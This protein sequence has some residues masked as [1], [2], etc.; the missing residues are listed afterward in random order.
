[1]DVITSKSGDRLR[2]FM[3]AEEAPNAGVSFEGKVMITQGLADLG[4]TRREMTAILAHEAGHYRL[5]HPHQLINFHSEIATLGG[6]AA[7]KALGDLL[8]NEE[9]EPSR[10]VRER[11]ENPERFAT[12]YDAVFNDSLSQRSVD[13]YVRKLEEEAHDMGAHTTEKVTMAEDR[14]AELMNRRRALKELGRTV[15]K[16][17]CAAGVP[18]IV[19]HVDAKVMTAVMRDRD[20][21]REFAADIFSRD[22]MATPADLESALRKMSDWYATKYNIRP[23]EVDGSDHPSNPRRFE[24]LRR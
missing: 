24:N 11:Q 1:M 20:Y 5:G 7:G 4:L 10:R 21:E 6:L 17:G 12:S 13:S 2:L 23:M 15:V 9:K 16:F 14:K 18:L 19:R 8:V 22:Y 3:V